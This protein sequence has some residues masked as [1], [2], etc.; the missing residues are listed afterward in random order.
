MKSFSL[1]SVSH[2][3]LLG[4][5]VCKSEIQSVVV[6]VYVVI[7]TVVILNCKCYLGHRLNQII[8][9]IAC[10]TPCHSLSSPHHSLSENTS[11]E[12]ISSL[13]LSHTTW[14]SL[15]VKSKQIL[16]QHTSVNEFSVNVFLCLFITSTSTTPTIRSASLKNVYLFMWI[17]LLK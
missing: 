1:A 12:F 15:L 9:I 4:Q 16:L 10:G 14:T 5:Y 13:Q 17:W 8:W 7:L 3:F 2:I 11:P 6:W